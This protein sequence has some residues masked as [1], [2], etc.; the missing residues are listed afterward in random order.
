MIYFKYVL[1]SCGGGCKNNTTVFPVGCTRQ[2]KGT[3]Q[4]VWETS[5]L[6]FLIWKDKVQGEGRVM[7]PCNPYYLVLPAPL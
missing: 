1:E 5:P 3:E 2:P 6:Y 4:V 7:S